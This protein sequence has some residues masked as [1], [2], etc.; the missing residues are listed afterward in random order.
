ML[1]AAGGGIQ[2]RSQTSIRRS[3]SRRLTAWAGC[4]RAAAG[5]VVLLA[6]S[7][8]RL[9]REAAIRAHP[10]ETG[11]IL[12]GVWAKGRP[13]VTHAREVESRESGPA[14]YILPAGTTRGLVEELRRSDPRLGYLGDWHS[15]PMDAPA[16]GVDYQTVRRLTDTFGSNDGEIVRLL[17]RRRPRD[18]VIDAHLAHRRSVRPA[19][20][21]WTGDLP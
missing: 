4:S 11:G 16:S 20:I 12:V 2:R 1:S 14:H 6:E 7:V 3:I 19:P 10:C 15:H 21:V 13:W 5:G 17:A 9:M 8:D 18:Y